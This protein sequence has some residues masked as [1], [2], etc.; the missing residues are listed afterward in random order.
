MKKTKMRGIPDKA[1]ANY[2]VAHENGLIGA[3]LA[4][5]GMR[6]TQRYTIAA[7]VVLYLMAFA[8]AG[9]FDGIIA[10]MQEWW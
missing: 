9:W 2:L 10:F 4:F 7:V 5:R 6:T 1:I 3:G 8:R